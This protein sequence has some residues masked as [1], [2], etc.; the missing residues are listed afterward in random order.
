[1]EAVQVL[2]G[3]GKADWNVVW[4]RCV[5]CGYEAITPV[6]EAQLT[7]AEYFASTWEREPEKVPA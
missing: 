7:D 6:T 3:P 1:M 5:G 2:P 4:H